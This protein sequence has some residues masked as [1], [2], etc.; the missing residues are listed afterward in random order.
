MSD[1]ATRRSGT[2]RAAIFLMTL[3]EQGAAQ[4]LQEFMGAKA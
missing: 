3:G 1:A 4:V 2:E